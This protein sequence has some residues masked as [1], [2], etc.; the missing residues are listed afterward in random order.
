M[1]GKEQLPAGRRLPIL[2]SGVTTIVTALSFFPC[3][4]VSASH[5]VIATVFAELVVIAMALIGELGKTP[6]QE[7]EMIEREDSAMSK[8]RDEPDEPARWVP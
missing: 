3:S 4:G 2:R 5:L 8:V 6:K 1:A 7:M